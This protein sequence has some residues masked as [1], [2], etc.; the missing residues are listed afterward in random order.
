M[1]LA[2]ASLQGVCLAG[3]NS[4]N[5]P[6]DQASQV[7]AKRLDVLRSSALTCRKTFPN[8]REE[9]QLYVWDGPVYLCEIV[10]LPDP[11]G[12]SASVHTIWWFD[13]EDHYS[14]DGANHSGR[15]WNG[16]QTN[17]HFD[18]VGSPALYLG[19]RAA[20]VPI[21]RGL[22]EVLSARNLE[23]PPGK[24][25]LRDMIASRRGDQTA[26]L[27]LYMA[28]R[29][30]TCD[31]LPDGGISAKVS[32]FSAESMAPFYHSEWTLGSDSIP[33]RWSTRPSWMATDW[34]R[35]E[36]KEL[37]L[38]GGI[39]LPVVY[40]CYALDLPPTPDGRM[41]ERQTVTI[42]DLQPF[43][44]GSEADSIRDLFQQIPAGMLFSDTISGTTYSTGGQHQPAAW[45]S[46]PSYFDSYYPGGLRQAV[47]EMG[48][49]NE[50]WE[51][52]K[53]LEAAN[54]K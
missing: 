8:G 40:T 46:M 6:C 7:I 38:L 9:L 5:D 20:V 26:L 18:Q 12:A 31:S 32:W 28:H 3:E 39:E 13:G 52:W 43:E 10:A 48:H 21:Q 33:R 19:L 17:V 53:H 23:S 41:S 54:P 11:S 49:G 51:R 27:D 22:D 2:L 1:F 16:D 25:E 37:G 14:W 35:V 47:A 36:T 29:Q 45:V 44:L 34:A 4:A 42:L 15:R 50:Y 24:E 30:R